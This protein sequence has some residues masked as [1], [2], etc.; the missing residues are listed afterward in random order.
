M[1]TGLRPS[2]SPDGTRLVFTD[3]HDLWV[4][5]A[6]GTG[7]RRLTSDGVETTSRPDWSP[8]GTTIAVGRAGD[9]YLVDAMTGASK[10]LLPGSVYTDGD[11]V[12][13]PNSK[14]LAF[15]R[16]NPLA[17]VQYPYQSAVDVV[18]RDGSNVREVAR[19]NTAFHVELYP[20]WC[21]GRQPDQLR[22]RR[23]VRRAGADPA[24]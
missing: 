22:L 3:G 10:D 15:I 12:W 6:D 19:H 14:Q 24:S 13:S 11:P 2:W 7:L 16:G 21:A 23:P 5:N 8:D 17:N 20:S 1:A 9:V 18:D 4:V